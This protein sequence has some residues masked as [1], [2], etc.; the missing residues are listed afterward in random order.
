LTGIRKGLFAKSPF[1]HEARAHCGPAGTV[2]LTIG[3]QGSMKSDGIT[4]SRPSALQAKRT[5]WDY[6]KH[7]ARKVPGTDIREGELAVQFPNG[8][9]ISLFGADN[10][11]AMRGIYLDGVVPD[12]MADG[13]RDLCARA[14]RLVAATRGDRITG[15]ASGALVCAIQ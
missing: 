15:K 13:R 7:F 4:R 8:A 3:R 14:V 9:R 1:K 6:L 12:E 10:P 11:E 5:S 2:R